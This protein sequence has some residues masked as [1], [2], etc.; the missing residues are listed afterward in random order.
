MTSSIRNLTRSSRSETISLAPWAREVGAIQQDEAR[1]LPASYRHVARRNALEASTL[2]DEVMPLRYA[3]NCFE[4][5]SLQELIGLAGAKRDSQIGVAR[6]R[7]SVQ[8]SKRSDRAH[9]LTRDQRLDTSQPELLD[10]QADEAAAQ[11]VQL[12]AAANEAG[13]LE[14][15]LGIAD[16][17]RAGAALS[18]KSRWPKLSKQHA[19][20]N[21]LNLGGKTDMADS[22]A[23][24]GV[25]IW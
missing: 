1:E 4:D 17:V 10:A 23:V 2:H 16:I 7:V 9:D 14:R 25:E 21:A 19:N 22:S 3:G 15:R 5:C 13:R 20:I 8:M 6:Q 18:H 24:H 11:P 12:L